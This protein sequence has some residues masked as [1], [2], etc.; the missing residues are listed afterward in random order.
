MKSSK[1]TRSVSV[2]I[3]FVSLVGC[4]SRYERILLKERGADNRCHMKIERYNDPTTLYD[5]EVVDYYGP[6]DERPEQRPLNLE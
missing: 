4:T 5:R 2:V 1:L 3:L 6:C